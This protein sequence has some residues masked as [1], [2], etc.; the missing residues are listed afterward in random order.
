[1]PAE[2]MWTG[3]R[4]VRNSIRRSCFTRWRTAMRKKR[5]QRHKNRQRF[6]SVKRQN[7][8]TA[9]QKSGRSPVFHRRLDGKKSRSCKKYFEYQEIYATLIL[10]GTG[11]NFASFLQKEAIGFDL[12]LLELPYCQKRE[13]GD[14]VWV[15]CFVHSTGRKCSG[16]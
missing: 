16:I 2:N 5:R 9:R 15:D 8:R 4:T 11:W 3:N 13:S 6:Y 1:M 14:V 12:C 10:Y 7:R